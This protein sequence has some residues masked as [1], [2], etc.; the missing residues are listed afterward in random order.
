M[1]KLYEK[2]KNLKSENPTKLYLFKSGI[3]YIF[4]DEDAIKM[5]KLLNLKLTK[6][7]ETVS[8]CGFPVKN[9]DKYLHLIKLNNYEIDIIDS[10]TS[11]TYSSKEYLFHDN[12]KKFIQ[13]IAHTDYYHLSVSEAFAFIEQITDRAKHI[14][15]DS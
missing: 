11:S 1:S 15:E 6:L 13:D 5:S 9:I 8:K 3:F 14:L 7:N 4:L 12:A 2:Y 10:A